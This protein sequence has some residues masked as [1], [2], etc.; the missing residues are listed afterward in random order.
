MPCAGAAS[1]A[2]LRVVCDYL[3]IPC[4]L[5]SHLMQFALILMLFVAYPLRLAGAVAPL[6][7]FPENSDSMRCVSDAIRRSGGAAAALPGKY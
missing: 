3:R 4:D 6:L 5:F 7:P 2:V 1:D